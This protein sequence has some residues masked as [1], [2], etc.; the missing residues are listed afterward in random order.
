MVASFIFFSQDSSSS[1]VELATWPEADSDDED[2][3]HPLCALEMKQLHGTGGT[4][5]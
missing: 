1:N 5:R 4:G 3:D 2:D